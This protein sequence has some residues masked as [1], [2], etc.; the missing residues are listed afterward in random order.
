VPAA[1]DAFVSLDRIL[2]GEPASVAV[3]VAEPVAVAPAAAEAVTAPESAA[4]T[5]ELLRDV[6]RFRARLAEAFETARVALVHEFAYAVLGR[7]LQLGAPDIAQIAL[8]ML[9]EH[10]GAQPLQ[11]RV[12]PADVAQLAACADA[13]PP[14]VADATLEP[15]DVMLELA[16]GHVDAR[17]GVRL[18]AVLARDG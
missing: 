10:P 6:R 2:R 4:V 5:A 17:L 14:I 7:E 3:A 11:L 13:L 12:A 18:A 8:R 15:G 1:D 16:C 9:A